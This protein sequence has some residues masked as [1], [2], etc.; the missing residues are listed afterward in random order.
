LTRHSFL[1]AAIPH[2]YK[3]RDIASCLAI[4]FL[5]SGVFATAA[6]RRKRSFRPGLPVWLVLAACALSPAAARTLEVGP[7]RALTGPR[8]A[9]EAAKDG[10]RVV[11]DPGVYRE[12]A[13]W[14]ASRLT[15]E[16][17]ASPAATYPTV[18]TGPTCA[19]RG[20]FIFLGNDITVR[21]LTFRQARGAWHTGA[22]ILMEGTNLTVEGGQFL[23]NEN[24]ILAGG[25]STSIVR[26]SRVLFRGNGSCQGAC[27]HALYVG[28][29]IAR[30]EVTECTF[31]ETHV[32]HHVKSRARATLVRD[33]RI[34]D[35]PEGTSSY[36]IDLPD[37]G[38][39]EI[40]NNVL[41][42]GVNSQN[43][44]AAISIGAE[45]RLN[46]TRTLEIRGNR[47]QNDG[48]EPTRF[49]RNRTDTAA[50]LSG[51]ALTGPAIALE[52]PGSVE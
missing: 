10:D 34:E 46:T 45:D 5:M 2:L 48:P 24:G 15:I 44:D 9:A 42:K 14:R 4:G 49:V 29:R 23:D 12:C 35:G 8:Q 20:L 31:F 39:G 38:D 21:G 25:T 19:D 7:T 6:A 33:S 32:G 28:K 27:A 40:V 52:G 37:G 41:R 3:R 17:L 22:G 47:F 18:I 26:V 51:N 16:A 13:I 36:L 11:F 30:L 50:R 1:T 43:R